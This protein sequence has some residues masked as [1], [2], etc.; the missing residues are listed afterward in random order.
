MDN[1][2]SYSGE[3]DCYSVSLRSDFGA[4]FLVNGVF[5]EGAAAFSYPKGEALYITVL[6]L[7]AQLLSYTV[8]IIADVA[9]C[10]TDLVV[11]IKHGDNIV[12][13]LRPR[14]NYVY[15]T[16]ITKTRNAFRLD[17]PFVP[18]ASAVDNVEKGA[19]AVH[20]PLSTPERLFR[21]IK[22]QSFA[23]AKTCCTESLLATLDQKALADFFSDYTDIIANDFAN[24]D[25]SNAANDLQNDNVNKTYFLIDTT[26][27]A[28]QFLFEI[29]NGLID[30]IV[31]I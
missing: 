25:N 31:E 22:Q 7:E 27:K 16:K 1:I 29:K 17:N 24:N 21:A 8:K 4:V 2:F 11:A 10:N 14:Y 20:A 9:L 18:F 23:T 5:S 12:I 6:P 3:G 28:T 19:L 26:G 30:N 15:N 13:K